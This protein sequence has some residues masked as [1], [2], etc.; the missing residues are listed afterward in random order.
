[1]KDLGEEE[2][3][4]P[5]ILLINSIMGP[6]DEIIVPGDLECSC[7]MVSSIWSVERKT[8][9]S[10]CDISGD[11]DNDSESESE[12]ERMIPR[13]LLRYGG[14]ERE[15]WCF[16]GEYLLNYSPIFFSSNGYISTTR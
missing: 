1:M 15:N 8:Y 3:M 13:M 4:L 16:L 7:N 14:R 10:M 2:I 12:E 11:S 5:R 6:G 9:R